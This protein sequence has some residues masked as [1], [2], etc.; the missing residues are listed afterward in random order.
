MP[1]LLFP[2]NTVADSKKKL[3]RFLSKSGLN[4][5]Y[6]YTSEVHSTGE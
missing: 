2:L 5:A 1:P 6:E 3:D 4:I